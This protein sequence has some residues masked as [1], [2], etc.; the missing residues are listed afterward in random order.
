MK[1]EFQRDRLAQ[2]ENSSSQMEVFCGT[3]ENGIQ[4][5]K[6]AKY[7]NEIKN[8]GGEKLFLARSE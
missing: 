6:Y 7:A 8:F 5:A 1:L 4:T 3:A 2:T